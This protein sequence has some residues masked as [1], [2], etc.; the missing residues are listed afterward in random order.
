MNPQLIE[1]IKR[2]EAQGF[3]AQQL[4]QWLLK[5]GYKE[6]AVVEALQ[7]ASQQNLHPALAP[8][9]QGAQYVAQQAAAQ[10]AQRTA[11]PTRQQPTGQQP[12]GQQRAAG[13][14]PRAGQAGEQAS[15]AQQTPRPA[16]PSAEQTSAPSAPKPPRPLVVTI[17]AVLCFLGGAATIVIGA[18]LL[19][20]FQS[21]VIGGV[22]VLPSGDNETGEAP[23]SPVA[24]PF[25]LSLVIA[26]PLFLFAGLQFL[27]GWGLWTLRNWARITAIILGFLSFPVGWVFSFLLLTKKTKAA[28]H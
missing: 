13:A 10:P 19:F 22:D 5:N 1:Y 14:P 26:V 3:S 8:G 12:T 15:P 21:A 20:G 23:A 25:Y 28:F 2:E 27:I 6:E 17:L 4:H 24:I 11:Q 18:G 16:Q 9:S 7:Y